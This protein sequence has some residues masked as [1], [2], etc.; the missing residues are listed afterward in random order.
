M[1]LDGPDPGFNGDEIEGNL[2]V[3][4][5]G[6]V[7]KGANIDFVIAETTEATAG[8]DLAAEYIVDN[9]L[10][11]VMS[12]SFGACEPNLGP[13]GHNL[14]APLWEQAAAQGMTVVVSAGDSGSA[15]CD[16]PN[17]ASP[18]A[19]QAGVFVNGIA[20]TPFNVAAGGTDFDITAASYQ[21]TYWSGA[22]ATVGGINDAFRQRN[23]FRKRPGMIPA[24]RTSR[25]R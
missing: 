25:V 19:A 11:P 14:E 7:A 16:D 5:S 12:E 15:G 21:S 3:Q 4:W 20:S 13:T 10:A 1:I 2:D 24:R 23:I 18:N 22:N 6:A 17:L 9:N 8:T